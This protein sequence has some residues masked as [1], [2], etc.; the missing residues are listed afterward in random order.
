MDA[1]LAAT[2]L[3]HDLTLRTR[4]VMD[5]DGVGL[6]LFNPLQGGLMR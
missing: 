3:A 6:R 2:A 5:F 1:L 4:N